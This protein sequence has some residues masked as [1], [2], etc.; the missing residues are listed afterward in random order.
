MCLRR[1]YFYAI[2]LFVP[3]PGIYFILILKP[4]LNPNNPH[5]IMKKLALGAILA[6]L[7]LASCQ[8]QNL[9]PAPSSSN[10]SK[11]SLARTTAGDN[12]DRSDF[13]S[14]LQRAE[15][16]D[17]RHCT[18]AAKVRK[19]MGVYVQ[20]VEGTYIQDAVYPNR[21]MCPQ[22]WNSCYIERISLHAIVEKPA[23]DG[24]PTT[25]EEVDNLVMV[26]DKDVLLVTPIE[27]TYVE[28]GH[29]EKVGEGFALVR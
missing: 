20:Y 3:G 9:A 15:Y 24:G 18:G 21:F 19:I 28:D 7:T 11:Q 23:T 26:P 1:V 2:I 10:S 5:L 22:S 8:K 29:V 4:I 13:L 14:I 25:E 16:L 17:P 6:S 27:P 12:Y